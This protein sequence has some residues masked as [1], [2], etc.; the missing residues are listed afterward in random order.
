MHCSKQQLYLMTSSDAEHRGWHADPSVPIDDLIQRGI[1]SAACRHF[2]RAMASDDDEA[3]Y[4]RVER[5]INQL[6]RRITT[7]IK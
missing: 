5:V 3:G 1:M 2:R 7:T 4:R 6:T